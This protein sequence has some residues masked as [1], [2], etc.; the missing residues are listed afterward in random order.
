MQFSFKFGQG[1]SVKKAPQELVA[2][3]F[4]TSGLKVVRLK[5][6][7]DTITVLGADI[8]PPISG[9]AEGEARRLDLVKTMSAHYAALTFTGERAIVRIV[10]LPGHIDDTGAAEQQ[11]RATL[12]LDAQYRVSYTTTQSTRGKQ[13]TKLL[14]VAVPEADAQGILAH[15][16]SGAPAP[17]A[18]ELAGLAALNACLY[19]PASQHAAEA[20]CIIECGARVSYLAIFNKNALI[21]ARKID[22]GGESIAAH[23]QK[24]LGLDAETA[25]SILSEGAIDISQAV[26]EVIEPFLRQ[27]TISRDFVER[28]ENCRIKKAYIS[29][30]M[31]LSSYWTS[32]I[33]RATG[34]EVVAWNPFDVMTMAPGAL[35][36]RLEGQQPRFAAA[37]GAALGVLVQPE[38]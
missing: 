28:E 22:V 19:G 15:V 17:Y 11:V 37:V 4:S 29:G 6:Q 3:D 30:G 36:E 10:S 8:L 25:Q 1:K 27:L 5:K 7:G 18:M 34:M 9:A 23:V 32:E 16:A 14:T 20:V 31:S 38:E 21:L 24:Q 13:E 35:P 2:L 26:R 33:R 12:G